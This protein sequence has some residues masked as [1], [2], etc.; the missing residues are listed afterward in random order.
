MCTPRAQARLSFILEPFDTIR[1]LVTMGKKFGCELC[2]KGHHVRHC[3]LPGAAKYR[4]LQKATRGVKT[5]AQSLNKPKRFSSIQSSGSYRKA[6]NIAYSGKNAR[7]LSK[8]KDDARKNPVCM[9]RPAQGDTAHQ[10]AC[11]KLAVAEMNE[12][13]YLQIPSECQE[14]KR[15]SLSD[16]TPVSVQSTQVKYG[17]S[18]YDC[19]ACR[20][21]LSFSNVLPANVGRGLTP[22]KVNDSIK[23]YT[24]AGISKPHSPEAA[25]KQL[26]CGRRT[27]TNIFGA[28]QTKEAEL[29]KLLN[30]RTKLKTNV[31]VDGHRLRTGRISH[32]KALE[33]YP[34]LVEEWKKKHK[35]DTLPEYWLMPIIILGA[36]ERGSDK[37]L[38]APGRLKLSAP[39]SKP[40]TEGIEEVRGA[41]FFD[42]VAKNTVIFPDGAVAWHTVAKE[43]KN[44]LK[45]ANVVHAKQQFVLKDT[46]AKSMGASRWRGTQVLDRRWEG[47]DAWVGSKI[48][49]LVNGRPNPALMRKVRSY[50]WRVRQRDVYKQLG[51]ACKR[52][53]T[54]HSSK[55]R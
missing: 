11:N 35:K 1:P 18:E 29:G 50:Q 5:T 42:K 21:A 48:A 28:L 13:G 40:G 3:K 23:I 32:K 2:G 10:G 17:C 39:S 27:M 45:V 38:L 9:R 16:H 46:R 19:K 37:G 26:Q 44:G 30:D 15:G 8:Q 4:K 49:T 33:L 34:H 20:S 22:A 25:A 7:R 24:S 36:W 14:C 54:R 51:E 47:L 55:P 6:T 43:S 53:S 52:A 12:V 31:E 41:A